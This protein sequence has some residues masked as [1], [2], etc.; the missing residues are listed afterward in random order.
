MK[1]SPV[2]KMATASPQTVEK[3]VQQ[4]VE[5]VSTIGLV[6]K[7]EWAAICTCTAINGGKTVV[8][9]NPK[10]HWAPRNIAVSIYY[11]DHIIIIFSFYTDGCPYSLPTKVGKQLSLCD[12]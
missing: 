5:E 11:V 2:N 1:L 4:R 10:K 6:V 8:T 9:G 12:M 7:V 3:H